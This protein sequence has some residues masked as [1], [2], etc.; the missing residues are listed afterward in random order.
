MIGASNQQ[1]SSN[2]ARAILAGQWLTAVGIAGAA[3][4]VGTVHTSVLCI[5]ASVLAMAAAVTWWGA[6]PMTARPAA[7]VLLVAGLG[8][9]AYTAVQCVPLPVSWLAAIAPHNADV[10]S[11]ALSPL[12]EA[13]PRW[14]PLSLDPIA[15]RIEVLKGIVYLLAFV[16]ALRIARSREGVGFLSTVIVATGVILAAA[17]LLHPAFKSRRLF[18]IYDPGPSIW[19]RHIAPLMNPNNLAGYLNVALC[20]AL[21]AALAPRPRIPRVIMGSI[22]VVLAATQVWV[23]SRGGVLTM[24]LGVLIV[25]TVVRLQRSPRRTEVATLSMVTGG[26][27]AVGSILVVLTGSQEASNELFEPNLSKLGLF[28]RVMKMMPAMPLFGCGRGAFESTFPAFREEPGHVTFTHPE[29]VIAQWVLEWGLP[30]GVAGLL[31]VAFALRPTAVVA[32]SATAA[33]AWAAL[34]A[35]AVQ[36]LGDLGTEVPGLMLAAVV[37]AA[38]V[39]AG[40]HGRDPKWAIQRWARAPGWVAG[41]ACAAAAFG[42]CL[43]STAFGNELGEVRRSLH[44]AAMQRHASPSQMHDLARAAMLRHPAEPYLPFITGLRASYALDDNPMPWAGAA[45]ERAQVYGPAHLVVARTVAARSPSQARL[46]YRLTMEQAPLLVGMVMTEAPRVAG[47][48][49]DATDLLPEGKDRAAVEGL[50]VDALGNRLPATC[51]RLDADLASQSPGEPGPAMRAARN[52]VDDVE[53]DDPAPWCLGDNRL[54]C[55]RAALDASERAKQ[56]LPGSCESYA[57]HARARLAAGDASGGLTELEDAAD[58]VPARVD[59]LKRVVALAQRSRNVARAEAALD[60]IAGAGCN[61]E[62]ECSGNLRWAAAQAAAMGD[63]RK[64]LAL[65]RRAYE[66]IPDDDG[67]LEQLAQLASACG[68]HAEA[69]DD[70]DRLSRKHPLDRRLREAAT[71]ERAAAVKDAVGL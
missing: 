8:L 46:E 16:V 11:R 40:S 21:A 48:Y 9:T 57:L 41:C 22:A 67:L 34:V 55:E 23:A 62:L 68:L 19:D 70:F 17:A 5:V 12:H 4:A 1:R 45:L 29:N 65:Y 43:A 27:A 66:R 36:N 28:M 54:R 52:D 58:R 56:L 49:S 50:I 69:A 13:G 26:A 60:R 47:S 44:D 71:T 15:T 64:A 3:L 42:L 61:G 38:I 20:L 24:A 30:V 35:L 33:G 31:A 63:S 39:V 10:W 6:E 7:T 18:G 37:C 51:V 2:Q 53:S 25:A 14:A 32:R 59:C